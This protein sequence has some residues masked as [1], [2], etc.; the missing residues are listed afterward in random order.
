[1]DIC[2]R[3]ARNDLLRLSDLENDHGNGLTAMTG[4]IY[5]ELLFAL[6]IVIVNQISIRFIETAALK[7]EG[8][9]NISFLLIWHA[10]RIAFLLSSVSFIILVNKINLVL[11]LLIF[12]IFYLGTK[13]YDLYRYVTTSR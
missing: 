2:R 6:S 10:V 11:F 8:P 1:M 7:R 9:R 3:W 13:V 12:I 5:L 4:N